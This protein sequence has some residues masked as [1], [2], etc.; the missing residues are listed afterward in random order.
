MKHT[1]LNSQIKRKLFP[2]APQAKIVGGSIAEKGE[3][4]YQIFLT[5][6]DQFLCGGSI[7]NTFLILTAAHCLKNRHPNRLKIT[8]GGHDLSVSSGTEQIRTA[9]FIYMHENYNSEAHINDI[10]I[11]VLSSPLQYTFHVQ[12]INLPQKNERFEGSSIVT[13][14]GKT[15]ENGNLANILRKVSLPIVSNEDCSRSYGRIRVRITNSMLCAGKAGRD[16][17]QGDSGGP[18]ACRSL[19]SESSVLCGVV[20]QGNG[21]GREGFPGIFT[22]TAL[23]IDW[24][25]EF[26]KK[27]M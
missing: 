20:S 16:A 10:A 5:Y 19:L 25:E 27:I 9:S 23:Y 24:I 18:A 12:S 14:W 17:C 8:A 21:C 3:F 22:K 7:L 15:Q 11:I 1:L 4:P 6:N 2:T 13:G 26:Q